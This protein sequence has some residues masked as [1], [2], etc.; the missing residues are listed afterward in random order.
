MLYI[1]KMC[2]LLP[3]QLF[4]PLISTQQATT[5]LPK[6]FINPLLL[7]I[8]LLVAIGL[9][10]YRIGD[11]SL[12][13]DDLSALHRLNFSS[14]S[15][16][17]EKG[18]KPD[19]HPAG[20]QVFLYIWTRVFGDDPWILRV[21]FLL[22]SFLAIIGSYKLGKSWFSPTTGL[23]VAGCLASWEYSLMHSLSIRPYTLGM[24]S[25]IWMVYCWSFLVGIT[26]AYHK[27]YLWGFIL[28]GTLCCYLHYFSLLLFGLVGL[29]GLLLSQKKELKVGLGIIFLL[30]LPHI[31]IFWAQIQKGGIG[32]WLAP[33]RP[34]FLLGYVRFLLHFSPFQ[35][36]AICILLGIGVLL[37]WNKGSFPLRK[38]VII[39]LGWFLG[40]F[41]IGYVY[42][43]WVNPVL[44]FGVLFFV[45]P[46][47]LLFIF[48]IFP[49]ISPLAKS[50]LVL[51]LLSVSTY[52]LIQD[53]KHYPLFYKRGAKQISAD[54]SKWRGEI[55]LENLS[56][57]GIAY[58]PDYL[59]Y[60]LRREAYPSSLSLYELPPFGPFE[61]WLQQQNSSH[62]AFAWL[63]KRPPLT[64][65]GLIEKYYPYRIESHKKAISEWYLYSKDPMDSIR[66]TPVTYFQKEVAI[67]TTGIQTE[68]EFGP[69]IEIPFPGPIKNAFDWIKVEGKIQI[70]PHESP[71][72]WPQIVCSIE[73]SGTVYQWKKISFEEFVQTDSTEIQAFLF[74]RLRDMGTPPR[75]K[76]SL[77]TYV[78]NPGKAKL[79][80]L[81]FG[82][83]IEEGNAEL[84]SLVAP[85]GR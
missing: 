33:P 75:D 78:W 22:C 27:K 71:T 31:P 63:N 76:L 35:Y 16:L 40:T 83:R 28:F 7:G 84:Y 54:I 23:L 24:F 9:R 26:H 30:Y 39:C 11:L 5:Y 70:F 49:E 15:E 1:W 46:F 50:L 38:R 73:E 51:A 3:C 52:S 59:D 69:T 36:L 79:K 65:L 58:H 82:M 20:T 32:G 12:G 56:T 55:G 47:L 25:A 43:L 64:Y 17:I 13:N 66:T 48:S 34:D 57:I 74:L 45:F 61:E 81:F 14:F 41:F 37:A 44:H 6:R 62:L 29:T 77:K 18:V 67:D 10:L 53:R 68:D 8:I 42:S 2:K 19:G 60:Y 4:H 80:I 85:V 21:P 72:Q